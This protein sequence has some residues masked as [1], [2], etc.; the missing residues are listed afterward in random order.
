MWSNKK[1]SMYVPIDTGLLFGD[2][3]RICKDPLNFDIISGLHPLK[4]AGPVAFAIPMMEEDDH[5]NDVYR[6]KICF[7]KTRQPWISDEWKNWDENQFIN[8]SQKWVVPI[9]KS[10]SQTRFMYRGMLYK[11]RIKCVMQHTMPNDMADA[12]VHAFTRAGFGKPS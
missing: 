11:G 10:H 12:M 2:I 4:R 8:S 3:I 7:P 6:M 1:I 9:G 5:G